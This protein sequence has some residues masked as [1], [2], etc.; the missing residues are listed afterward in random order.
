MKLTT[1]LQV[2]LY[3]REI[4]HI[5]THCLTETIILH[6]GMDL[7]TITWNMLTIGEESPYQLGIS[8][9]VQSG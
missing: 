7:H 2:H 9:V 6:V 5:Y 3:Y 4:F 1:P 8:L